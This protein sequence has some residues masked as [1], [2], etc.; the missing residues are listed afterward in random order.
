MSVDAIA[1]T[2]SVSRQYLAQALR[3][4]GLRQPH[5]YVSNARLLAATQLLESKISLTNVALILGFG[6]ASDLHNMFKRYTG[7]SIAMLREQG[8]YM[9]DHYRAGLVPGALDPGAADA[10]SIEA[11]PVSIEATE[12]PTR[13]TEFPKR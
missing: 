11:M 13:Y 3:Q 6:D 12:F 9:Y 4:A 2:V 8:R 5:W 7:Q 1:G 10:V